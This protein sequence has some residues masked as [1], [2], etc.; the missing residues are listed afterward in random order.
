MTAQRSPPEGPLHN[1]GQNIARYWCGSPSESRQPDSSNFPLTMVQSSDIH[2]DRL[3]QVC[4]SNRE[5]YSASAINPLE[6]GVL[7]SCEEYWPLLSNRQS[8]NGPAITSF[9]DC[10]SRLILNI[11]LRFFP[12]RIL[13]SVGGTITN[14]S[15]GINPLRLF[16]NNDHGKNSW[17][18]VGW[19]IR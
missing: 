16:S 3:L 15:W 14:V 18:M 4:D 19:L 7:H 2:I 13:H 6:A 10:V 1:N 17:P 11:E 9:Q 8:R 5:E 12:L